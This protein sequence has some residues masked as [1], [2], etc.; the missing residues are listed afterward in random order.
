MEDTG[1][2]VRFFSI[3][4]S[5]SL[6]PVSYFFY[7]FICRGWVEP[8][9]E[10]QLGPDTGAVQ[11]QEHAQ[12]IHRSCNQECGRCKRQPVYL[13]TFIF[14]FIAVSYFVLFYVVVFFLLQA[15]PLS[16]HMFEA[17]G[18]GGCLLLIDVLTDNNSRCHQELK[19]LLVRNGSG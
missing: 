18:P 9:H 11:E 2:E 15:K 4:G 12:V 5:V 6:S 19:R 16:Q 8:R 17:R 10:H 7:V 14:L 13:N 3:N 1:D